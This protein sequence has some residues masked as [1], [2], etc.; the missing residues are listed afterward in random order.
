MT[1]R[2]LVQDKMLAMRRLEP[3]PRIVWLSN[4]TPDREGGGGQRRQ[5]FQIRALLS[6]GVDV[7][8]ASL[9]STQHHTSL[10]EMVRVERF[11]PADRRGRFHDP[12]LDRFLSAERADGAVV[13]HVESVPNVRGA[14]AKHRL[15][16]LLDFQ[17]VNS[18]WYLA[19]GKRHSA[20]AWMRRERAALR[21]AAT[22]TACSDEER[23]ALLA[24]SAGAHVEVVGN[25]I[26]PEEWP[27][28]ALQ[29]RRRPDIAVA[30]SW[31]HEPNRDGARWLAREVWPTIRSAVPEARLLLA[32]PGAPPRLALETAGIEHLGRVDDLASLMG[33]VRVSVVPIVK[34]IG[35]RVKFG[36]ALA[37]GAAVVSTSTGAEGFDAAGCFVTADDPT[38]FAG[39]CIDLLRA[40]DRAAALG[41]AGREVA[42]GRYTWEQ[43]CDPLVQ[44]VRE[45]THS[46]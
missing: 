36:E 4:E 29:E 42:F 31:T 40:P 22:A 38:S 35:A 33:S 37:S 6:A 11:G 18:R 21:W 5:Y 13:A 30:S 15:P 1:T 8:V 17:N 14:L 45:S 3:S 25:G 46:S 16:W 19:R 9:V 23:C 10:R 27:E 28:T 41:R 2:R 34:G 44:W 7:R 12:A 32:G 39:A 20:V 26:A 24:V 43:R